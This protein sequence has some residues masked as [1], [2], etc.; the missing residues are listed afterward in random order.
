MKK[1]T[2]KTLNK[3][4]KPSPK[5]LKSKNLNF[6]SFVEYERFFWS[7]YVIVRYTINQIK[8][9]IVHFEFIFSY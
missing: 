6:K 1:K 2:L 3:I 5:T 9:L 8:Y 7:K 4:F